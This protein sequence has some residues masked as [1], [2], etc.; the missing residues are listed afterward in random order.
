MSVHI[1]CPH[2]KQ[3]FEPSEAFKHQLEETVLKEAAAQHKAELARLAKEKEELA[4][5]QEKKLAVIQK[6]AEEKAK[7]AAQEGVT[8]QLKDQEEQISL[9]KKRADQAEEQELKIRKEKRELEESKRKFELEKQRQLDEERAKI[10]ELV[11][12]EAEEKQELRNKEK[13]MVIQ[14]LQ[15]SLADAQ[16][17]AAQGSQ[18]SQGEVFELELEALLRQEF[19]M[20]GITEVKKGQRGADVTQEVVDKKGS[21][22][23]VILWELKN[24]KWSQAWIPTLKENQ[25]QA[26]AQIA[27]L[28]TTEAPEGLDSF[29]YQDGV[30]VVT[31]KMAVSLAMALRY[32]LVRVNFEKM[33]NVNK[34]QKADLLYQYITST[35]FKHRVE[36]I[37]EA[38]SDMRETIEK[39]KRWFTNKWAKQEMQ[40][41][42]VV[43]NTIGMR[44]DLEGLIGNALPPVDYLALPEDESDT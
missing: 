43:D 23:G 40:I 17:K 42:R 12:K 9:L 25:R 22:C 37:V 41:R 21:Q 31:R 8:K 34:S 33:A 32:D 24:A 10:R 39:E 27:V 13:D 26:K 3:Q 29:R 35:E 2:C 44:A 4:V 18:Q 1:T 36:A 30:W 19:P 5:E 20:D 11:L 14:N 7:A 16:R 15:K 38:F 6:E 28:V